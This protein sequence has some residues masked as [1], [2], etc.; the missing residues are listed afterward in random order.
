MLDTEN[1]KFTVQ[2]VDPDLDLEE[3]DQQAMQLMAELRQMDEI[4]EVEPA[5]APNPPEGN[6]SSGGF[7]PGAVVGEAAP[8]VFQQ[9]F[10]FISDR[11]AHKHIAMRLELG[12]R[13][14]DIAA[15]SQEEMQLLLPILEQFTTNTARSE[16]VQRTILVLAA[17]P[18]NTNRLRLD[19]EVRDITNGLKRSNYRDQLRLETQWAVRHRD[20]QRA[21][22]DTKPSI[23]HFCGHSIGNKTTQLLESEGASDSRF[24]RKKRDLET[25]ATK[26]PEGLMFEDNN[27]QA[28]LLDSES[29]AE[30]FK[31][32]SDRVQC[33]LLNGCYSETQAEAISQHIEYVIG[34]S[35]AIKDQSAI[36]FAIGFYDAIG[37]GE[38]IEF[39]FDLGCSAIRMA[40]LPGYDIPKLKRK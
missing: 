22:L 29:L 21:M 37:A 1:L 26:A 17:N 30:F 6:K 36:E 23:V 35:R 8:S 19:H 27:G 18:S 34:M 16:T 32:F 38:S 7:I 40:K 5:I 31:L 3:R 20:I 14:I 15:S 9:V 39:A 28:Y 25:T 24:S 11:F 13:A 33:V 4:E 2:F 12:D 10:G